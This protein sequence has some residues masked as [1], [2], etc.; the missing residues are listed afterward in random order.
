MEW[1]GSG[2]LCSVSEEHFTNG[3]SWLHCSKIFRFLPQRL[4]AHTLIH[5]HFGVCGNGGG[6]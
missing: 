3:V 6:N 1:E 4:H 2:F 5:L